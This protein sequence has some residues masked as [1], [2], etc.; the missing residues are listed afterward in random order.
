MY[1]ITDTLSNNSAPYEDFKSR[2]KKFI[3]KYVNALNRL[4][5]FHDKNFLEKIFP[6]IMDFAKNNNH[7]I[8]PTLKEVRK[9]NDIAVEMIKYEKMIDH[10]RYQNL[11]QD[12][13]M[14]IS[15]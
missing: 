15:I 12:N 4:A 14:V 11:A 3:E 10:N 13:K 7:K 8:L 1:H 9:M 6:L 5:H 2:D